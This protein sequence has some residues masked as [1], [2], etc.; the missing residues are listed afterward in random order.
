MANQWLN[1]IE[2]HPMIKNQSLILLMI[3]YYACK[4]DPS[5]TVLWEDSQC[6][7]ISPQPDTR[8]GWRSLGEQ[9]G[10]G[11]RD[12]TLRIKSKIFFPGAGRM[13]QWVKILATSWAWWLYALISVLRWQRQADPEF[14]AKCYLQSE[15]QDNLERPCLKKQNKTEQKRYLPTSWHSEFSFWDPHDGEN[16]PTKGVLWPLHAHHGMCTCIHTW[17]CGRDYIWDCL[18]CAVKKNDQLYPVMAND[19]QQDS[20]ALAGQPW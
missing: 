3:L 9:L 17:G 15:L 1:Q 18:C 8:W 5:I 4:Q 10:E 13:V 12:Q 19:R 6:K 7:D 11:L 14:E 2:T 20:D 16:L